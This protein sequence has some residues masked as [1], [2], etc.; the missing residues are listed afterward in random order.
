MITPPT[1]NEYDTDAFDDL[2]NE[3][4]AV[5]VRQERPDGLNV[6]SPLPDDSAHAPTPRPA[7]R[8][9]P[10]APASVADGSACAPCPPARQ[11]IPG[12][13]E[14]DPFSSQRQAFERLFQDDGGEPNM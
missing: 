6:S 10:V 3:A 5:E 9:L 4:A 12:L 14:A 13:E 7:A 1:K 2:K 8:A 11:P